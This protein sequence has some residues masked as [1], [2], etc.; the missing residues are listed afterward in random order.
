MRYRLFY[1]AISVML[2][3]GTTAQAAQATRKYGEVP[4]PTYGETPGPNYGGTSAPS[5]GEVPAPTYGEAPTP[6][7]DDFTAPDFMEATPPQPTGVTT[8]AAPPT[9]AKPTDPTL[10]P[11]YETGAIAGS[12]YYMEGSILHT[13]DFAADGT[14]LYTEAARGAGI[15]RRTSERGTYAIKG[16]TLE[17]HPTRQTGATASGTTGG[18]TDTLTAGT[19]GKAETRRYQVKLL[20]PAGNEGMILDGVRMKAK[21]W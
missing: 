15:S 5:Y 4:A 16:N 13:W 1:L 7:Y 12:Y 20:G 14:Y 11:R 21:T 10:A 2:F 6:K 19:A 9:T 17:V 18:H 3:A 8:P